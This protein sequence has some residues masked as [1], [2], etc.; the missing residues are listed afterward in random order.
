MLF[1]L[2]KYKGRATQHLR[3]FSVCLCLGFVPLYLGLKSINVMVVAQGVVLLVFFVSI[4][5]CLGI[6]QSLEYVD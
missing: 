2:V 5:S 3:L 1:V 4:S 6:E